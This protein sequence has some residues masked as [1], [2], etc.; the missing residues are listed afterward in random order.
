MGISCWYIKYQLNT[1]SQ[2]FPSEIFIFANIFSWKMQRQISDQLTNSELSQ[3][4][5]VSEE[6]LRLEPGDSNIQQL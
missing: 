6:K 1:P 5:F 3:T 4:E 2:F